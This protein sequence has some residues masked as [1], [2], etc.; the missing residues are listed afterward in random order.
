MW[1]GT[2]ELLGLAALP[3]AALLF[4]SF[5][6]HGYG[7]AKPLGLLLV[8][9]AN[10]WLGST[11]AL[12]NYPPILWCML[13][14]L[15]VGG[16]GLLVLT[17][18]VLG[19]LDRSLLRAIL[20]EELLFCGAF[21]AWTAIRAH[22][23]DILF[24]ERPMDFM[25]L[26]VSGTTHSFPPPDAWMSGKTVN[27]YY[28]GHALFAM[29]GRMAGVDPA[30]GFNLTIITVFALGC[31]TAY[32][33]TLALTG[34]WAWAFGGAFAVMLA[35]DLDA[36]GQVLTQLVNGRLHSNSLNLW[37]LF[38]VM[39]GGCTQSHVQAYVPIL[40]LLWG[41]VHAFLMDL[42]FFLLTLAFGIQALKGPIVDITSRVARY[43]WLAAAAVSLGMLMGASSWDYP[44]GALFLVGAIMLAQLRSGVPRLVPVA[45]VAAVIPISML[46]YAPYLV[47][48]HNRFGFGFTANPTALGDTFTVL[49]GLL[50]PVAVFTVWRL[51]AALAAHPP[52]KDH[53]TESRPRRWFWTQVYQN[54]WLLVPI[55][56]A[57]FVVWPAR[58]DLLC[59]LLLAANAY[60][61]VVG[62]KRDTPELQ[63]VLLFG[64]MAMI[65]LLATDCIYVQDTFPGVWY[66]MTTLSH[67]YL[68]AWMFLAL[69]VPSCVR[70]VGLGLRSWRIRWISWVW[71]SGAAV[72]AVAGAALPVAGVG[73]Q[74]ATNS[75]GID[76]LAYL[77]KLSPEMYAAV[78]WIRQHTDPFDVIVEGHGNPYW[79]GYSDLAADSNVISSLTGRPTVI[80]WTGGH[81]DLNRGAFGQGAQASAASGELAERERDVQTLYETPDSGIAASILLKYHAQYVFVGPF[82][83]AAYHLAAGSPDLAKFGAFLTP[84][85]QLPTITLYR[86][87]CQGICLTERLPVE[88]LYQAALRFQDAGGYADDLVLLN[89]I[90]RINPDYRQTLFARGWAEWNLG[91]RNAAITDYQAYLRYHPDDAQGLLNLGYS[92][93][94]LGR[95]KEAVSPLQ[96]VLRLEPKNTA[97]RHDLALCGAQQ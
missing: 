8:F 67:L 11:L 76:G 37:C 4:R 91:Q 15:A 94:E 42:P 53:L 31:S 82:E 62:R 89:R 28:L 33:V 35:G 61:L 18:P 29:I 50:T 5:P 69:A 3:L 58:A 9:F 86:V 25:L 88:D 79:V 63:A 97:A 2:V 13:A 23:P 52:G 19:R 36:A 74:F 71:Y 59:A 54:A 12:A 85:L 20:V 44:A 21:V 84:V 22:S 73:S 65:L 7:L 68:Q 92:L 57:L 16:A 60:L 41:D 77:K 90:A 40:T 64:S 66:R 17:R 1:L 49:G 55:L 56:I 48:V 6:D 30:I 10:W 70:L 46:L 34:R 39:E 78:L 43:A 75:P 38:M 93:V 26:Q 81:E 51:A 47:T 80:G 72:L 95:C 45:E 27:Y 96:Q 24:S 87:P 83:R 32:S 14:F